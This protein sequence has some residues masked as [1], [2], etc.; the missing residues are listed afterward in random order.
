[1]SWDDDDIEYAEL[2][3]CFVKHE[4]GA[5][6][7]I[8]YQGNEFWVPKSQLDDDY[9]KYYRGTI[10]VTLWFAEKEDIV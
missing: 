8:R 9:P 6:I 5:A 4:T 1:M 10:F 3:D 7:L 2:E